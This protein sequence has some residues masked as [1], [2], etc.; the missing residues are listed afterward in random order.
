MF[1]D[2]AVQADSLKRSWQ[3]MAQAAE[4]TRRQPIIINAFRVG[5]KFALD[6][7]DEDDDAGAVQQAQGAPGSYAAAVMRGIRTAADVLRTEILVDE[8][9]DIEREDLTGETAAGAGGFG[10]DDSDDEGEQAASGSAGA[11]GR[12]RSASE[13]AAAIQGR[14]ATPDE[15]L[16]LLQAPEDAVPRPQSPQV[17]DTA[18]MDSLWRRR[19]AAEIAAEIQSSGR[20]T[21]ADDVLAILTAPEEPDRGWISSPEVSEETAAATAAAEEA[22]AAEAAEEAAAV[23]WAREV[24]EVRVR[25]LLQHIGQ[26]RD[27]ALREAGEEIPQ[28]VS[29]SAPPPPTRVFKPLGAGTRKRKGETIK[30]TQERE[31]R[32]QLNRALVESAARRHREEASSA[33]PNYYATTGHSSAEEMLFPY[34]AMRLDPNPLVSDAYAAM[35]AEVRGCLEA[36]RAAGHAAATSTPERAEQRRREME[37][38]DAMAAQQRERIDAWEAANPT[39]GDPPNAISHGRLFSEARRNDPEHGATEPRTNGCRIRDIRFG[40][41]AMEPRQRKHRNKFWHPGRCC[42]LAC[43]CC[44]NGGERRYAWCACTAEP[45]SYGLCRGCWRVKSGRDIKH[46]DD[47]FARTEP[48]GGACQTADCGCCRQRAHAV[49]CACPAAAGSDTCDCCQENLQE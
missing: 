38:F 5:A 3:R 18:G 34:S 6:S 46:V 4:E 2:A 47:R 37:A 20:A 33:G 1:E 11:R 24:E 29:S 12:Q 31:A 10:D 43:A 16:E 39:P 21:T 15:V 41:A 8:D 36:R 32:V 30:Q 42:G 22:A 14:A 49:G 40:P 48:A 28:E 23:V 25:A 19:S 26:I 17:E 35:E 45:E 44:Y 9:G 13:I 27:R 7:D